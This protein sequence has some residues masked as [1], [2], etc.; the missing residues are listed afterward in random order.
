MPATQ[1]RILLI[2]DN[3]S[4]ADLIRRMLAESRDPEFA[5]QV[6][7][8]LR[9]GLAL[10]ETRPYDIVLVDLGLPDCRQGLEAALRVRTQVPLTPI[11]VLTGLEDEEIALKSWQLDIQDYLIKGEFNAG[12][13]ARSIRNAIQR[14]RDMEVLRETENRYRTLFNALDDAF[15]IIEMLYDQAGNAVDY[16]F[17]ETNDAF[18]RHS[19]L[20]GARGRRIREL[21]PDLE[22]HWVDTYA[23][24]AQTG[25]PI[26]FE[27]RSRPM[28][29]WFSV[30][31]FRFGA[32]TRRQVGI[33]FTD[34]T[35]RKLADQKLRESE[36]KFSKAFHAAPTLISIT[37]IPEGRYLDVNE[38]FLR[39]LGFEREEILGHT[40]QE[41]GIWDSPRDREMLLGRLHDNQMVR[42]YP[43]LLRAKDGRGVNGLLSLEIIEIEGD[44]CLLTI[45]RNVTALRRSEEE[46]TRL[47]LMVESSEDAIIG[48][49]LDGIITSWNRGAEKIYGFTADE[50]KGKNISL[51]TPKNMPDEIEGLL[52]AIRRGETIERLETV[53]IR[54]DGSEFPVALTISP[55]RDELGCIVGASTI[56]RDISE[57]KAAEL[58]IVR[59]NADLETRASQLELANRDL[60]AFNYS[61]AHDLRQ[62]LTVISSFCQAI[63][64]FCG[65]Q[66]PGECR[67]FLQAALDGV[68]RM[69]RLIDALLDFARLAHTELR[70]EPV[71]LSALASEIL[72]EMQV[73]EPQR[74]VAVQVAEKA[75]AYGDANLLR[76][77]LLNL[78]GNAW[79]YTGSRA[80]AVIEFGCR[81]FEGGA[82]FYVRDNGLGF[83]KEQAARIFNPFER[84][85]GAER[86]RGFGIGLATVERIIRRHGGNIWAE[87][88]PERGATFSFTLPGAG[89][90]GTGDKEGEP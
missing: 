56:A 8:L 77:V 2:E 24:V 85:P 83:E 68:Q 16:R 65:A 46:R 52:Q 37:T 6:A 90:Q 9:D 53:R 63:D 89:E 58:E 20:L 32:A 76:L 64:T 59:L 74:Q 67:E 35:Q 57:R 82:V 40:S 38:E 1:L 29:R 22:Q 30:Y 31:A 26:R 81:E 62:P 27:N 80:S 19:G 55:I 42:D 13:L 49:T 44:E 70:R 12:L 73:S 18:D 14:K 10:L 47:A 36:E 4:D 51:L 7:E 78:L 23:A 45:T 43:A 69:N 87:G 17:L 15:C 72:Q 3:P 71:D 60:E 33:Q 28:A 50:V 21:V 34:I 88:E 48:K 54:K 79:K 86:Y 39:T 66:L 61:V 25:E 75:V 11:M 84:L 41:L 5:V